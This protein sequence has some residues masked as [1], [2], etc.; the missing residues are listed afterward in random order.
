M[1]RFPSSG[2]IGPAFTSKSGIATKV[3]D[4][5]SLTGNRG[6]VPHGCQRSHCWALRGTAAIPCPWTMDLAATLLAVF[7]SGPCK[8]RRHAIAFTMYTSLRHSR[9]RLT[10]ELVI[11]QPKPCDGGEVSQGG[12]NWA[13]DCI[14]TVRSITDSEVTSRHGQRGRGVH[15]WRR[16]TAGLSPARHGIH[17]YRVNSGEIRR[18][19]SSATVMK[20]RY[21]ECIYAVVFP[22]HTRPSCSRR[23]LT[24]ELVVVQPQVREGSEVTQI[25][26]N[27]ACVQRGYQEK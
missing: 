4:P 9:W 25:G 27:R 3:S 1:E 17:T 23:E 15:A 14:H 6:A 16:G 26:R 5:I 8:H 21:R 12:R 11:A 7:D 18:V 24:A 10:A 22:V 2:G 20:V 13:C 19:T